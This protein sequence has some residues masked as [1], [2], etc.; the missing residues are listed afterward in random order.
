LTA[1]Q[2]TPAAL[3]VVMVGIGVPSALSAEPGPA[4][5]K[6]AAVNPGERLPQGHVRGDV[7][8][9]SYVPIRT[10]SPREGIGI[11][12]YL[13][14][15]SLV[16]FDDRNPLESFHAENCRRIDIASKWSTAIMLPVR[17]DQWR[18]ELINLMIRCFRNREL[19]ILADYYSTEDKANRPYSM[20]RAILDKLWED[21][22]AVLVNPEGDRATGRQLINNIL[23]NCCGDE[24]ECG[25]GTR[26][27]ETVY[28]EFDRVIRLVEKE[29]ES[30]F[31]HIKAWYN[32][33]GYAAL[34][35][36]GCYAASREDVDRQKRVKLP[37]NTQAIGVDVYHYWLHQYSPFDPA[38]LSIPREKVRAHSN[39]WQRLRT[40]YYPKGLQ[41]RVCSNSSDPKTWLPECW[42]DT[43]A[44]MSAIELAGAKNAMMWYIAVCGQLTN[45]P[46]EVTY[47]TPIE[48]MEAYY[49]ELKAGPWVALGWWV[50]G[51]F[52]KITQGGL[53]YYD[54]TL[55]H[56]TPQHPDGEPYSEEMLDY[57][58]REY[59]ALKMRMFND[60]V[61][62]Q[63]RYLNG[64]APAK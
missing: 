45:P 14:E 53:R 30:P 15:Y 31:T 18:D 57:W 19:I 10:W 50:F 24:G 34:D 54:K 42:N 64:S 56:Y 62:N 37:P 3:M 27:L 4:A 21:R 41:V 36:N 26:G 39:E 6:P 28:G 23:A 38:D 43:H 46:A 33:I 32:M 12:P 59:L 16:T 2:Y 22:D 49:D 17:H 51:D 48:T 58:R 1:S 52:N 29:G 7:I 60:V 40:R 8:S 47:T 20:A 5:S 61:Y 35:Y 55:R 9:Y 25:L 11:L 44:L 13:F 63:F